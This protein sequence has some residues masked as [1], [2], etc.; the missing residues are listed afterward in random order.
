MDD[1]P[2]R[3]DVVA[4]ERMRS[5]PSCSSGS[6][7][8]RPASGAEPDAPRFRAHE[9]G[10]HDDAPVEHH[11]VDAEVVAVELPTPRSPDAG[12]PKIDTKYG[13]SPNAS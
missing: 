13:H 8:D 1:R 9:G 11:R 12:D 10:G 3:A 6:N 5:S 2:T 4:S 7:S